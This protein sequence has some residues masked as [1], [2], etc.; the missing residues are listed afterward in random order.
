MA[1]EAAT[2]KWEEKEIRKNGCSDVFCE[3]PWFDISNRDLTCTIS[4]NV[5]NF[6]V[7]DGIFGSLTELMVLDAVFSL[8][9][10]NVLFRLLRDDDRSLGRTFHTNTLNTPWTSIDAQ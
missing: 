1:V 5:E 4:D 2:V 7:T 8:E 9:L 3:D 6:D 10:V